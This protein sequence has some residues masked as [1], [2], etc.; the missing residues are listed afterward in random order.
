L[1]LHGSSGIPHDM[2]RAAV[3]HGMTKINIGTLLNI[4]FTDSIR[5]TLR[6]DPALID[7]RRYLTS[8]RAAAAAVV[9]DCMTA[10]SAALADSRTTDR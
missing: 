9:A 8:A 4:A 3:L 6:E 1:V 7:P 5:T 2:L 10:V